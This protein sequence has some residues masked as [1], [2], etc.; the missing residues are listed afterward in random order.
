MD[1]GDT[2]ID[3]DS[4]KTS[5]VKKTNHL[6]QQNKKVNRAEVQIKNDF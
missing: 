3:I 6:H 5:I 4:T 2:D 1:G